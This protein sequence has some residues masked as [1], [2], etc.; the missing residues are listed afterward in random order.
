MLIKLFIFLISINSFA[1]DI[2]VMALDTGVDYNHYLISPHLDG[3]DVLINRYNYIDSYGHGTHVAALILK[4]V[5]PQVKFYSCRIF[6][7]ETI[8][9]NNY[10][11]CYKRAYDE[12]F[13]FINYSGGGEGFN[14]E[15]YDALQKLSTIP[16]TI[17]VAAGNIDPMTNKV[18][19][20]GNPCY[21]YWPACDY[22]P[23]I[24]VVGNLRQDGTINPS[25]NYG[26]PG[27]VW[28]MGTNVWSAAPGNKMTYM[29]GTSMATAIRT[30]RLIKQRC[31]EINK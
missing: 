4:G 14:Q 15:E 29:T 26:M 18:I 17:V 3:T 28:E 9:W 12:H 19:N 21:G 20:L 24:V 23:N 31:E 22:F 5:C 1:T 30:N 16:V 2:K 13:D 11:N 25:S 6:D 8:N 27:M 10:Y 7:F